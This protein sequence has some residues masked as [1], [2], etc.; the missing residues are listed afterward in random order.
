MSRSRE[1]VSWLGVIGWLIAG[2]ALASSSVNQAFDGDTGGA[3]VA[4]TGAL[5]FFYLSA[6]T[7]RGSR[8]TERSDER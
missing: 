4:L 7:Y 6:R 3:L 2:L 5:A 8:T 1:Q